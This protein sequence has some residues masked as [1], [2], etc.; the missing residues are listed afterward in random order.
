MRVKRASG[1]TILYAGVVLALCCTL[2]GAETVYVDSGRGDDGND[3]SQSQPV[4][5]IE[6]AA[7]IVNGSSKPGPTTVKLAPGV[8]V[9]DEMLTFQNQRGYTRDARLSI[10]ATNLPDDPAWTPAKM[11]IVM[12]VMEGGLSAGEMH[13]PSIRIEVNHVTV[14]GIKFIGNPRPRTWHYALWRTGKDLEDLL[15]TQCIFLG[16]SEAMQYSCPICANG[17][18]LVVD[19]CIFYDCDIPVI[20]WNAQGGISRR[21]AMRYCI[22]DEA[23]IAAVWTCQTAE[24][25][26]FHHNVMTRG[27]YVWMRSP[28]N[29]TTY[30]VRDCVITDYKYPS[31]TGTAAQIY[32]PTGSD[33][34]FDEENVT[35]R[36]TVRLVVPQ[37]SPKGLSAELPRN[38][39]HVVPGTLGSNLDAGLFNRA[40][41][42]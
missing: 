26:D 9:L 21:N 41:E 25:F 2:S 12:S 1:S 27:Q 24:D 36:G 39:L 8:Y 30:R 31:G 34:T 6:R 28:A 22:V 35:K 32:G 29:K 20:F 38:Y 4:R 14:R 37:L 5:T 16:G 17:H 40:T 13:A 42:N 15:I 11:P 3:G 19:H 7:E 10:V 33:V 18:E 23:D